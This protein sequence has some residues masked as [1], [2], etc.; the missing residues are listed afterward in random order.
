M[1]ENPPPP[2][3]LATV[4]R[5]RPATVAVRAI[6]EGVQVGAVDE[7]QLR[8]AEPHEGQVPGGDGL[9]EECERET[10]SLRSSIDGHERGVWLG[11]PR[12]GSLLAGVGSGALL[13]EWHFLFLSRT[14]VGATHPTR[15][16]V[17]AGG[18]WTTG[19]PWVR[20]LLAVPSWGMY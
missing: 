3:R 12:G 15:V 18:H 20:R 17:P 5:D 7:Q 11:P 10:T 6:E 1:V 13:R 4:L 2:P 14:W 8:S 19:T 9:P 16:V